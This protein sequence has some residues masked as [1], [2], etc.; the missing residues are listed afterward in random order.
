MTSIYGNGHMACMG[1]D[2]AHFHDLGEVMLDLVPLNQE[3]SMS[4][5]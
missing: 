3:L 5:C 2:M 1:R 4:I